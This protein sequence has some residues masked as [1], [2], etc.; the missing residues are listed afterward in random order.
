MLPVFWK[1]YCR[2]ICRYLGNVLASVFL[3][4]EAYISALRLETFCIS[5]NPNLFSS[6]NLLFSD[7]SLYSHLVQPSFHPSFN[8]K[9]HCSALQKKSALYK[10]TTTKTTT[11]SI[12]CI[13]FVLAVLSIISSGKDDLKRF[14]WCGIRKIL[15]DN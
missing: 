1:L 8:I 12:I 13:K 4:K 9:G 11:R 15:K 7:K 14:L 10:S 6:L 2:G 3:G 5:G